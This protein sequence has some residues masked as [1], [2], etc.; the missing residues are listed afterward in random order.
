MWAKDIKG[1][2]YEKFVDDISKNKN[3]TVE[4]FI[5]L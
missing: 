4:R 1:K 3:E 2:T 5:N